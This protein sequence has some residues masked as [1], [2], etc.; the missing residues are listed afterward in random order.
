MSIPFLTREQLIALLEEHGIAPPREQEA[1]G[2]GF[3]MAAE[4]LREIAEGERDYEEGDWCGEMGL[5]A[6]A[7]MRL[8]NRIE[9]GFE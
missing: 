3:E 7:I 5:C 9:R 6:S 8:R 2:L 1:F 4:I